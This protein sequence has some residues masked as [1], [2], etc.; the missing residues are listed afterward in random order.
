MYNIHCIYRHFQYVKRILRFTSSYIGTFPMKPWLTVF[1]YAPELMMT[2]SKW[3]LRVCYH[4]SQGQVI[5]SNLATVAT[6]ILWSWAET[7]TICSP[8]TVWDDNSSTMVKQANFVDKLSSNYFHNITRWGETATLRSLSR[9]SLRQSVR[10]GNCIY[11]SL[12]VCSS[13]INQIL[14]TVVTVILWSWA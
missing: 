9:L 8:S 3:S 10:S 4:F 12:R 14:Q 7:V 2:L 5:Y 13:I 6:V 1:H 11:W